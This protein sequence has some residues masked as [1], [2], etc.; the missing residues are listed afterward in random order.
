MK[1]YSASSAF[2]TKE[3]MKSPILQQLD[4]RVSCP[5]MT[6]KNCPKLPVDCIRVLVR[7]PK[8]NK[9]SYFLLYELF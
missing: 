1:W 8:G 7:I 3:H 6:N 4:R 2:K 5:Y 9:I